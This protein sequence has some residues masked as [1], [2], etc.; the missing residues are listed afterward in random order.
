MNSNAEETED[1]EFV[2]ASVSDDSQPEI[3]VIG[4]DDIAG[5]I[6]GYVS[7]A[8]YDV[9]SAR[10][11]AS[12]V[13]SAPSA[14]SSELVIRSVSRSMLNDGELRLEQQLER[15]DVPV[16]AISGP[17][18]TEARVDYT[19]A[20]VVGWLTKP[21]GRAELIQQIEDSIERVVEH[22]GTGILPDPPEED[23]RDR[24]TGGR[25]SHAAD[26]NGHDPHATSSDVAA[27][28]AQASST[29]DE[30]ARTA[31]DIGSLRPDESQATPARADELDAAFD[32]IRE[33]ET[34][35]EA[36][37]EGVETLTDQLSELLETLTTV[38]DR[39]DTLDGRVE[40]LAGRTDAI[41][42]DVAETRQAIEPLSEGLDALADE[43]LRLAET[44][45]QT[46][47]ERA[48]LRSAVDA[49]TEWQDDVSVAFRALQSDN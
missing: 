44:V 17:T 21:F 25:S 46:E 6:R 16:L 31:S 18:L 27:I 42:A 29:R 34:K 13:D 9:T 41:E 39:L 14:G 32:R 5:I 24:S 26:S 45:E 10:D 12:Y 37:T 40:E 33:L 1:H 48:E 2:S 15:D 3:V 22:G 20:N 47:Q 4:D 23:A 30:L 11:A 36:T 43:Q 38:S 8:G 35:Q 19:K 49:L 28:A 7:D